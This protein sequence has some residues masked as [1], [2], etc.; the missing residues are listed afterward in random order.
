M[1]WKA[2]ELT[3]PA[4][5]IIL[6]TK[7]YNNF[8]D[9]MFR[10]FKSSLQKYGNLQHLVVKDQGDGTYMM[11]D[12]EHRY[13][14]SMELGETDFRCYVLPQDLPEVERKIIQINMNQLIGDAPNNSM[15][16]DSLNFIFS[17]TDSVDSV[18][19][20]MPFTQNTVALINDL[21]SVE[22]AILIPEA[23]KEPELSAP[24]YEQKCQS[25]VSITFEMFPEQRDILYSSLDKV[26]KA[27]NLKS[28]VSALM[29]IMEHYLDD[30]GTTNV[31]T[32]EK[33]EFI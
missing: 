26:K 24:G 31:E 15:L 2:K 20:S 5:K 7:N 17:E 14:A 19:E 25:H 23:K 13:R 22:T 21:Y 16:N 33:P 11:V 6:D 8:S 32:K 9:E 18:L 29:I 4:D 3:I 27:N 12:G 1:D 28:D 30:L 10:K